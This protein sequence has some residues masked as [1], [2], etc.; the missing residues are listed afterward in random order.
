VA[1][2]KITRSDVP[3]RPRKAV[4][5][6]ERTPEWRMMRADIEKGLKPSEALQVIFSEQDKEKYNIHNRRSIARFIQKYLRTRK[7]PYTV[8]SFERRETGDF[9]ILVQHTARR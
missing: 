8:K 5:R 9:I 3:K 6:F 1:Y 4:S 7:L 2:K